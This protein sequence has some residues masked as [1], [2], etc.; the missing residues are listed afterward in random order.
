[1]QQGTFSLGHAH[2]QHRSAGV[3]LPS[4]HLPASK[5]T[6][7][8]AGLAGG[9]RDHSQILSPYPTS[10]ALPFAHHWPAPGPRADG[11]A[12]C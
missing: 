8:Q 5:V 3:P 2:Q 4:P 7:S 10:V 6:A 1:M 12:N 11:A 9:C